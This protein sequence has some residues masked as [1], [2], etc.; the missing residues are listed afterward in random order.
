NTYD[1][2]DAGQAQHQTINSVNVA[3]G[4]VRVLG[5]KAVLTA[6]GFLRQDHLTYTPSANPFA[7]T[8]GT[9]SQ[10]RTLTNMGG[11]VDLELASG[12][13]DLKLGGTVSATRLAEQFTIGFT[14]PTFNSPC[15]DASGAPSADVMLSSPSQCAAARLLPNDGFSPALLPYDLTRR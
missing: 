7:D 9:V 15:V 2:Q 4:Y 14:D 3:P 11:K 12:H 8:P 10:D 1:Q 6:N 5:S 13:H